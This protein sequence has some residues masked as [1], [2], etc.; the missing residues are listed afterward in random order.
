M[1]K[2]AI[3]MERLGLMLLSQQQHLNDGYIYNTY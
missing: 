2:Q 3:A 1:M